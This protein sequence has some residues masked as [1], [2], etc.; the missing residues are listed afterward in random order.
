MSSISNQPGRGALRAALGAFCIGTASIAA[1]QVPKV[2]IIGDAHA[3]GAYLSKPYADGAYN[4]MV[5]AV[6]AL[7][8]SAADV[9]QKN[10]DITGAGGNPTTV[11]ASDFIPSSGGQYDIVVMTAVF[12]G[13]NAASVSAVQSAIQT[14]AANAFFLYPDQCSA[15]TPNIDQ[16]T[17]PIINAATGWNISRGVLFNNSS[18][19]TTPGSVVLNGATPLASSFSSLNPMAVYDYRALNNVPAYNVLYMPPQTPSPGDPSPRPT[20]AM[21]TPTDVANNTRVNNV[22]ALIVPRTQS[23]NGNGACI[24][25]ISD[26]NPLTLPGNPPVGKLGSIMVNA[27]MSPTGSC[28]A[29]SG[30][31]E[32]SKTLAPPP[33]QAPVGW[34]LN[35]QFTVT[36]DK[37]AAGTNYAVSALAFSAPGTQTT[38]VTDIPA[39]ANCSVA[40]QSPSAIPNFRWE[41]APA[42][43][44]NV[45]IAEGAQSPAAFTNTLVP[46]TGSIAITKTLAPLPAGA[47]VTW[48]QNFNFTATCN[49][50]TAGSTYTATASFNAAGSQTAAIANV[51]EGAVCSLSETQPAAPAAH[52]WDAAVFTPASVTVAAGQTASSAITNRLQTIPPALGTT[53]ITKT[54]APLPAGAPVTWPLTFNFTAT[55]DK[56]AANTP[57]SASLSFTAPGNQTATLDTIPAGSNCT[58]AEALPAAPSGYTWDTPAFAP[59]TISVAGG[60][61]VSTAITNTLR[62]N[63]VPAGAAPVPSNTVAGLAAM[64]ALLAALGI[65]QRRNTAARASKILRSDKNQL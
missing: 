1:A 34:P 49:L 40:E 57:Y 24:F 58:L 62:A 3:A 63:A 25:T 30:S 2:L 12:G 39:G 42:A 44:I 51:P 6:T 55:C 9:T 52:A 47:P 26:V 14:R 10:F 37:P 48:P 27:A 59:A 5:A 41:V 4:E 35:F 60:Q 15:C 61:S 11:T 23:F 36:C 29:Q 56:P 8:G 43:P 65:R 38:T 45:V 7:G 64:A 28:A 13:F 46:T 17:S 53:I 33:A 20:I 18:L 22:S 50:P 31:I 19:T 21:P 54:L 32:I 16:I